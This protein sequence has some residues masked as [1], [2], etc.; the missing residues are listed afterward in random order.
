MGSKIGG[1]VGEQIRDKTTETIIELRDHSG[2]GVSKVTYMT[3]ISNNIVYQ[4][5]KKKG[6]G[7]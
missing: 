6:G 3:P 5:L 2:R 1:E 7:V 4:G